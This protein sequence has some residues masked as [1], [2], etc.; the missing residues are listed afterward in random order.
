MKEL[1]EGP[2]IVLAPRDAVV[3]FATTD[4]LLAD[5]EGMDFGVGQRSRYFAVDGSELELVQERG[6]SAIVRNRPRSTG[7]S[8]VATDWDES[9]IREAADRVLRSVWLE[10][11]PR[12]P[13][14]LHHVF[15]GMTPPRV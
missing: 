3:V 15:H 12:R 9:S 1:H 7:T 11:F 5:L 8:D 2:V 14:W 6:V 10:R 4:E 13:R